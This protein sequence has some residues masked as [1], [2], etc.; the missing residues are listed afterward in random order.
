M[1]A[2]QARTGYDQQ[3]DVT[4]PKWRKARE[5]LWRKEIARHHKGDGLPYAHTEQYKRVFMGEI[6][7][8]PEGTDLTDTTSDDDDDRYLAPYG[9]GWEMSPF[10]NRDKWR[11]AVIERPPQS[12]AEKKLLAE[13]ADR[14]IEFRISKLTNIYFHQVE[15]RAGWSSSLAAELVRYVAGDRY[16]PGERNF[17][18]YQVN[19]VIS[20]SYLFFG[21]LGSAAGGWFALN[22]RDPARP[23]SWHLVDYFFSLIDYVHPALFSGKKSSVLG[24]DETLRCLSA[25]RKLANSEKFFSSKL[26]DPDGRDTSEAAIAERREVIARFEARVMALPADH[27]FRAMWEDAIGKPF[28]PDVRFTAGNG[29]LRPEEEPE[30]IS[31]PDYRHMGRRFIPPYVRS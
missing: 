16:V 12:N 27:P 30:C 21:W 1:K 17:E 3:I 13:S 19:P 2:E 6:E 28:I 14:M 26:K 22:K 4:D 25:V 24:F 20:P 31:L 8:V 23:L 11:W 29:T 18:G 9:L 15:F 10:Q 7:F 5:S